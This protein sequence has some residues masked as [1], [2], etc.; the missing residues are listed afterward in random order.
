[1]EPRKFG[2]Q[3]CIFEQCANVAHIFTI[4]DGLT[5]LI[6]IK[7]M[8]KEQNELIGYYHTGRNIKDYINEHELPNL[9]EHNNRHCTSEVDKEAFQG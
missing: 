3:C 7:P 8:K 2:I 4:S 5:I 6:E 1:M 9:V